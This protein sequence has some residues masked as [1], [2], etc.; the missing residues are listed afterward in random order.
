MNKK[1]LLVFAFL[2]LLSCNLPVPTS[3]APIASP[4]SI[5]TLTPAPALSPT[6]PNDPGLVVHGQV[7]FN[8]VGLPGV[9]I[10]KRFNAYSPD[11]IATTDENGYYQSEFIP[12]PG[13]EMVSVQAELAGYTFSPE[14]F[15]WRHYHG[16]ENT[17]CDFMATKA[18][19]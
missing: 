16:Y 9:K 19:Q 6:P 13:D 12:I 10:Y 3:P 8:G 17:A 14:Y 2:L 7:T 11:L 1:L 18:P 4:T 5:F 15:Y